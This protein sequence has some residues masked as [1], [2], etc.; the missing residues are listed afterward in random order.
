MFSGSSVSC[1][2]EVVG[3]FLGCERSE[4]FADRRHEGFERARGG[5]AEKVLEL[6][7]DLLDGVQ[8]GG[9]LGRKNSL[10]PADR[11]ARR[12]ALPLWLPRLSRITR[13][14]D[15]SVGTSAVST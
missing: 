5:V 8:V 11:M 7:E 6:G 12:M 1:V 2:G 9:V 10:A 4:E 14:P 13:S 15:L 3:A